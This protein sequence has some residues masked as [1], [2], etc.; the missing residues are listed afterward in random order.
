VARRHR[1]E[2]ISDTEQIS[3]TAQRPK[4]R[5]AC[6]A[7]PGKARTIN[8]DRVSVAD[9]S[10][11][12]GKADA[13]LMVVDGMGANRRGDTASRIAADVVPEQLAQALRDLSDAP[14]RDEL[15]QA[16]RNAV[17]AANLAVWRRAQDDPD[18]KGMGTTCV[19]ALVVG[20]EAL[21]C[22]AGDSRAYVLSDGYLSQVTADHSLIQEVVPSDAGGM[23]VED[24]FGT[25]IT[26]GVGLSR[27]IET[28]L[29]MVKLG[30]R[31]ALLLCTDGLTNMVSDRRI[32]ELL[33]GAPSAEEACTVLVAEANAKGGLDN[34]GVAVFHGE[35]FEPH[36]VRMPDTPELEASRGTS[37]RSRRRRPRCNW[38][39]PVA[40]ILALVCLALAFLLWTVT[41]DRN[42]LAAQV[43]QL[44]R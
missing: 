44:Q 23:D 18:L 14:T 2:Q 33:A 30:P 19:A 22:H 3:G 27:T 25:V 28:D 6:M 29:E 26:R 4:N 38:A 39:V 8:C 9:S 7:D 40:A 11:L 1:R 43:Q 16:L 12:A 13:F 24:R 17:A 31:D 42:R 5:V 15:A 37:G 36:Q 35:A 32:A 10:T 20:N 21:I 34:I 41:S